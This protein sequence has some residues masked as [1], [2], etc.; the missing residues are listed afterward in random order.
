MDTE[1]RK[2]IDAAVHSA[3]TDPEIGIEHLSYD[4]CSDD[5]GHSAVRGVS[6]FEQL[7]HKVTG[8]AVN[9]K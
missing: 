9:R 7:P 2:E 3:K 5:L 4:I 1:I 6:P 8:Q